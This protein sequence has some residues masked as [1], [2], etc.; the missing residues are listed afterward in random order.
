MFIAV[1]LKREDLV[2]HRED[3][4]IENIHIFDFRKDAKI[5]IELANFVIFE[6]N[7]GKTKVL[8]NRNV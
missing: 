5:P 2:K 1:T 4:L 7:D 6:D 3:T 8:K